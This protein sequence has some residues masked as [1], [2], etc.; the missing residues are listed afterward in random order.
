[1]NAS[2]YIVDNAKVLSKGQITLPK[3]VRAMLRVD[4]GDRVML[5]CDGN[6]VIMMNSSVYAKKL[7]QKETN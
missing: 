7:L 2:H 1:M 5:I 4:T 6:R 3:D